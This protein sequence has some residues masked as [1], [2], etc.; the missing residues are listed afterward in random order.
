MSDAAT[1][2]DVLSREELDAL[3]S[4]LA[5]ERADLERRDGAG[6]PFRREKRAR[7]RKPA[8]PSLMRGIEWFAFQHGRTLSSTYQT[9]VVISV[10]GWEESST[11]EFADVLLP[12]DRVVAFEMGEGGPQGFL[13][14]ARPLL[15]TWLELAFGAKALSA[16]L[17]PPRRPYTRIEE[18]FLRRVG[19]ELLGVLER[20]LKELCPG[21]Y[22]L[23]ALEDAERLRDR[24][25][26]PCL[27]ASLDLSGLG[28]V[29]RLRFAFPLAPFKAHDAPHAVAASGAERSRVARNVL[30]M[31]VTMRAEVGSAEL[32]LARLAG[33]RVGD[34][35]T[36][37]RSDAADLV[38]R[39]DGPAKFRAVRGAVGKRLAVQV[40]ERI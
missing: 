13:L 29:C 1:P 37:D 10:I 15:F 2:G 11:H 19:A 23:T 3:L 28:D 12:T 16:R 32:S 35:V 8:L 27:L 24:A 4:S 36:I 7:A 22:R 14:V 9:R 38:L 25:A 40:T 6:S 18:R 39:I 30:E 26:T 21:P 17:A 34:V 5:E 20:S 33:L 31:P